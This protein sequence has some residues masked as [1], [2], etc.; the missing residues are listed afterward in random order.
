MP[1]HRTE[2]PAIRAESI[3]KQEAKKIWVEAGD[4]EKSRDAWNRV[5]EDALK[6]FQSLV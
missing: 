1:R 2:N 3:A 4:Y 5:Y 6:E